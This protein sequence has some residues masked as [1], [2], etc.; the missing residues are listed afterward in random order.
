MKAVQVYLSPSAGK[1]LIGDALSGRED[2]LLAAKEH[3]LAVVMGST[4][5]YFASALA[6]RLGL[7]FEEKGFYRGLLLPKSVKPS[8]PRQRY[9]F[10][11]R[12]GE[13]LPEKSIFDIAPSLGAEDLILKGGNAVQLSSR[14]V[15]ILIQ[16]P[17]GGTMIPILSAAVGRRTRLIHP[18]G[19]EKRVDLPIPMLCALLNQES[20]SGLRMLQSPGLGYTELDAFRDLFGLDAE[21]VAAGGVCGYEGGC[22]FRLEGEGDAVERL[23]LRQE[24][25]GET[26]AFEI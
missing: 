26:P 20:P 1:K 7:P 14:D 3:T 15:G 11:L 17:E 10:I 22:L 8:A 25:E 13:L 4:N 24:E 9:D 6:R 18:V 19:V 2:V 12:K 21:L 16:S 5:T 23:L